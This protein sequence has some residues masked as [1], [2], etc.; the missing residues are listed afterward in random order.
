LTLA[1]ILFIYFFIFKY[2]FSALHLAAMNHNP[3]M[4]QTLLVPRSHAFFHASNE[5]RPLELSWFSSNAINVD[6]IDHDGHTALMFACEDGDVASM[7]TLL[8]VG[9]AN[10]SIVDKVSVCVCR[11]SLL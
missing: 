4:I 11:I 5:Q 10:L 2:N 9:H 8:H 3:T 6:A 1:T 7:K